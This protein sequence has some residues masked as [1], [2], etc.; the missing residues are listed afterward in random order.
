MSH[1]TLGFGVFRLQDLLPGEDFF[2]S[3]GTP[4]RVCEGQQFLPDYVQAWWSVGTANAV[5]K[6]LHRTAQVFGTSPEQAR[7]IRRRVRDRQRRAQK[8]GEGT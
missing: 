6:L 4:C 1:S 2:G 7:K 3:D 8:K 5:K